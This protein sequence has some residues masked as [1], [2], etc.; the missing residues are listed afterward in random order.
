MNVH[1][2]ESPER[3]DMFGVP[4]F[5]GVIPVD[6]LRA[7]VHKLIVSG[8]LDGGETRSAVG[9]V[10]RSNLMLHRIGHREHVAAIDDL[11]TRMRLFCIATTG[12]SFNIDEC[13]LNVL[14][15]HAYNAVHD[16][17]PY[18]WSGVLWIDAEHEEENSF[19][20]G[21]FEFIS[22]FPS[23]TNNGDSSLLVK[24]VNGA[25]LLFPST[26]KHM[27]HPTRADRSRISLSWNGHFVGG[28]I[29]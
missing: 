27:V 28:R 9:D 4:V 7:N 20:A 15:R 23:R 2:M 12:R 11:V 19:P 10:W 3:T 13:W 5:R 25:A 24:P 1:R 8:I 21:C 29:S 14:H 6:D 26:I 16:H 18:E 17:H 22:P